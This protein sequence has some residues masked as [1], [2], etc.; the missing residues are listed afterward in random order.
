[1]FED[2]G[3]LMAVAHCDEIKFYGFGLKL[4][5]MSDFK[6]GYMT[7]F[8]RMNINHWGNGLAEIPTDIGTVVF[9][10]SE[11]SVSAKIL[12][13]NIKVSEHVISLLLVDS[14]GNALPLYYTHNIHVET[15]VDGYL[16]G[17]SLDFDKDESVTGDINVYLMIDTYPVSSEILNFN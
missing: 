11:N 6:T 12:N 13:S 9:S 4:M 16:S 2:Y 7:V 17:V 1:M 15:D 3:T 8:G 5:G 10:N 14:N